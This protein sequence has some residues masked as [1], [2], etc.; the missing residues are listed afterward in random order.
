MPQTQMRWHKCFVKRL[1]KIEGVKILY[2]RQ[3]NSVFV[4]LPV[5]V[6]TQLRQEG[7][8][9][10]TFIGTGGCRMMCSW[11]TQ[12]TDV[13]ELVAAITRLMPH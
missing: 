7:W 6:I 9:F 13:Q 2:P 3:A 10:Y 11:D 8:Q 4:E 5:N 1:Q 12:P